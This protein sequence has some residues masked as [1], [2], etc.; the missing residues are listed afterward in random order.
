MHTQKALNQ[1]RIRAYLKKA[2]TAAAADAI[3]PLYANGI[4]FSATAS[5]G[6]SLYQRMVT[7]TMDSPS[8]YTPLHSNELAGP[9][10]LDEFFD[11]L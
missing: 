8:G 1:T 11:S 2:E 9:L 6:S 10:L 7:A 4:S 3:A 5:G